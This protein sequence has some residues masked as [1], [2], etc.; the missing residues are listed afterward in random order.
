MQKDISSGMR[1]SVKGTLILICGIAS[2]AILACAPA[3]VTMNE[4]VLAESLIFYNWADYMPQSVLDAFTAEYGVKVTYLTFESQEEAA[5]RLRAGQRYDV[6][7]LDHDLILPLVADGLLA[8]INYQ[9]ISN[10]KNISP[11]FR[12]LAFD[13]GNKHS[14]P[15]GYGTTGLV[16]R[17]D[18]VKVPI[19]RWADLWDPRFTGKI[20]V[21]ALPAE[22][23]GVA[24][25]SLGYP[26]NSE[27]PQQ[28]ETALQ[29]ML[30]LKPIMVDDETDKAIP[31]LLSGEAVIMVGWGYDALKARQENAAVTYVLPEEGTLLWGDNFVIPVNSTRKNTA[32]LF[33]NFLL[34][35]EISAQIVNENHYAN[36]AEAAYPFINPEILHNPIIFPPA[37]VFRKADWYRPLSPAGEQLYAEIWERFLAGQP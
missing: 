30:D 1:T 10:F 31:T 3:E 32:E 5:A 28:L 27:D 17:N 9:K 8:E 19:T 6:V 20:A 23:I 21:R 26:L 11:S 37:E 15:Y 25:K 36:A 29:H 2:M 22:F 35:P 24:L 12:D 33:I 34:R 18:L 14:I 13:P 4:P 16:V 7:I